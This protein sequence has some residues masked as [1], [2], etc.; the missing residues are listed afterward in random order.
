[1]TLDAGRLAE[2]TAVAERVLDDVEDEFRAGIGAPQEVVK[3]IGDWATKVDLSIERQISSALADRTGY[4]VH[5]EE[6]GGSSLSEGTT[7]VLDPIDG[8]ANYTS[9]IPICGISLAL[10][11][12]GAPV[13][14]LIRLPLL[15]ER[16]AS[17][18]GG[19]AVRNGVTLPPMPIGD[20][21]QATVTIGTLAPKSSPPRDE[22]FPFRFRTAL[23]NAVAHR[24]LR[25]RM[26]GS[27]AVE[28]AWAATGA[29]GA[30]VNFGNTA[31]DNAA[32]ALLIRCG[33]GAVCDLEGNEWSLD[34]TSIVAGD[35]H[36]V[37]ELTDLV[38]EFRDQPG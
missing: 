37:G 31:W 11:V 3:G 27:T 20:L 21:T 17:V 6:F 14:G 2:L 1:V 29:I 28:L 25:V 22:R 15:G 33:G 19:P 9:R 23:A 36:V 5:G 35:P 10:L 38:A 8:T 32:G 12:D 18:A 13:I 26:F 16:Y 30:A 7:W 24:A 4:G 34:S